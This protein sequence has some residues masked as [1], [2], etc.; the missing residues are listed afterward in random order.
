MKKNN[1]LSQEK[2]NKI[3]NITEQL[4][5][6]ESI[7]SMKETINIVRQEYGNYKITKEMQKELEKE[8]G[9]DA[10]V[11][12]GWEKISDILDHID[13][14]EVVKRH[15]EEMGK[16][17]RGVASVIGLFFGPVGTVAHNIPDELAAKIV[18]FSGLLTPEHWLNVIAKSQL[19]RATEKRK[20]E[21]LE[22]EKQFET[23]PDKKLLIVVCKDDLLLN[24]IRKLVETND[25][26][27]EAIIGTKDNSI[28]FVSWT[29]KTW[30]NNAND[31]RLNQAKLLFVG[32][33]EETKKLAPIINTKFK[34][35]G[36][37]YGWTGNR[38]II[39][40]K[41]ECLE[42][43][44]D[45]TA[46]LK[47]LKSIPLPETVKNTKKI[48]GKTKTLA[49]VAATLLL[50]PIGTAGSL[51]GM[52]AKDK[53]TLTQQMLFYGIINLYNNDLESFMNS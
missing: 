42:N 53:K 28:K 9:V 44:K 26:T 13:I 15:P 50:G 39:D 27:E 37:T 2:Q 23:T 36:V 24:E 25:D 6:E 46:F 3:V 19:N 47:E 35:F 17:A 33:V 14:Y 41:E 49:T 52:H 21:L 34:K 30:K 43:K 16:A 51:I 1:V 32:D 29:E 45:Y 4:S 20:L 40:T 11:S 18:G 8:L 5:T 22:L 31:N 38:A 12:N 10:T 7:Q 48:A